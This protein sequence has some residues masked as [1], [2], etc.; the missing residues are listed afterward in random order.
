MTKYQT[1]NRR[2]QSSKQIND[3]PK[4][5][6][7]QLLIVSMFLMCIGSCFDVFLTRNIMRNINID[8]QAKSFQETTNNHNTG[9]SIE[10][11]DL[12]N[13]YSSILSHLLFLTN[14]FIYCF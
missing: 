10:I 13:I 7:S 3:G 2:S 4:L 12:F 8:E 1:R 14:V 6:K 11:P 9:N 5:N